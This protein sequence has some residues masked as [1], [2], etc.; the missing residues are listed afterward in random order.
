MHLPPASYRHLKLVDGGNGAKDAHLN[1][2]TGWWEWEGTARRKGGEV[3]DRQRRKMKT[4]KERR[5]T[6]LEIGGEMRRATR[7]REEGRNRDKRKCE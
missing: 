3:I 7:K 1:N 2:A 4:K 5:A 6:E